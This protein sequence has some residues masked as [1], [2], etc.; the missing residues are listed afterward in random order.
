MPAKPALLESITIT[1]ALEWW[2]LK[3]PKTVVNRLFR[4]A[5]KADNPDSVIRKS[6]KVYLTTVSAML[7]CF[8]QPKNARPSYD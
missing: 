3:S 7:D 6:G 4:A 2:G 5:H 1:E 8:G